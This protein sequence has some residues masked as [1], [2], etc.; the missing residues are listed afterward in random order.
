MIKLAIDQSDHQ[1][2]PPLP[3]VSLLLCNHSSALTP[4]PPLLPTY[5]PNQPDE[6]QASRSHAPNFPSL[7]KTSSFGAKNPAPSFPC[8]SPHQVLMWLQT[9]RFQGP[10]WDYPGT[11]HQHTTPFTFSSLQMARL[12]LE[13]GSITQ[14]HLGEDHW[15]APMD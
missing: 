2:P 7:Y 15:T 8:S 12:W 3:V 4:L 1:P 9:F 11:N 5:L 14:A 10:D 13:L 6:G